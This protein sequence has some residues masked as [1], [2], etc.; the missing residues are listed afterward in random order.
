M[1]KGLTI[2]LYG[3]PHVWTAF[4]GGNVLQKLEQEALDEAN[5]PLTQDPLPPRLGQGGVSPDH[6]LWAV[7][8]KHSDLQ[9]KAHSALKAYADNVE[10]TLLAYVDK[11]RAELRA[12]QEHER[13]LTKKEHGLEKQEEATGKE[14]GVDF[15]S[16]SWE[17]AEA[18]Q[19]HV[20][21]KQQVVEED[22]AEDVRQEISLKPKVEALEAHVNFLLQELKKHLAVQIKEPESDQVA[23]EEEKPLPVVETFGKPAEL[24]VLPPVKLPLPDMPLTADQ[25]ATR[26]CPSASVEANPGSPAVE[27]SIAATLEQ[28]KVEY[29]D[30]IV[31]V[32]VPSVQALQSPPGVKEVLTESIEGTSA[33]GGTPVPLA[34]GFARPPLEKTPGEQLRDSK[35]PA[36]FLDE[37]PPNT[38]PEVFTSS[39]PPLAV[40]FLPIPV[41]SR[42]RVHCLLHPGCQKTGSKFL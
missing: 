35:P 7:G 19:Q 42:N 16:D 18:S 24:V 27:S 15:D 40:N 4:P 30:H 3:E 39:I 26:T 14:E 6:P 41:G 32:P 10:K 25:A 13:A 8:P 38:S 11:R 23:A 12:L 28:P 20:R 2:G 5:N 36:G 31:E 37:G 9:R 22:A 29:E 1:V 21:A 33:V 34:A 17:T